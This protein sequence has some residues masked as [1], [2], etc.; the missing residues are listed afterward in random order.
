MNTEPVHTSM[1]APEGLVS[2][3]VAVRTLDPA[4]RDAVLGDLIESGN[5]TGNAVPVCA[6]IV[7]LSQH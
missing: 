1:M 2:G 4:E 3:A 7:C 6:R 5:T